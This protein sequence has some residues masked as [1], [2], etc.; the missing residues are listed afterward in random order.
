MSGMILVIIGAV[1]GVALAY[2]AYAIYLSLHS[3]P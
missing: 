3:L 1:V 2:V